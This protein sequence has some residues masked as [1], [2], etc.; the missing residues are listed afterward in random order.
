M[1]NQFD[2]WLNSNM[3]VSRSV[4]KENL[5][6]CSSSQI[7]GRKIN[8]HHS[9]KSKNQQP[10]KP[11]VVE[12]PISMMKNSTSRTKN[13]SL[14]KSPIRSNSQRQ[15]KL[16]KDNSHYLNHISPTRQGNIQK[17]LRNSLNP[18]KLNQSKKN[19]RFLIQNLF[20]RNQ[21]IKII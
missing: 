13:K 7:I 4:L 5:Q 10:S 15:H 8:T 6:K 2:S 11:R 16:E 18:L 12:L 1:E 9:V 17:L 3:H 21:L 20:L 14:S 19:Q